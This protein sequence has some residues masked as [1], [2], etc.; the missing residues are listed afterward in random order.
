MQIKPAFDF[1]KETFSEWTDDEVPQHAAALAYYTI[2]S[3]APLLLV[4]IAI[5]GLV[6]GRDAVQGRLVGEIGGLV[7]PQ[8]GQAIQTMVANAGRH[9]SGVLA[10]IVG[11]VTILF[12]AMGVFTQL[13]SSLDHIWDVRPKPGR[14]I[15]GIVMSRAAAFGMLLGIGFLL[16]VSLVLS[17]ALTA[18]GAYLTGLLPAAKVLLQVVNEL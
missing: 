16:L 3:L 2:F 15:K 9:G 4:V 6:F 12:G 10:T 17:A 5:A 8:G 18:V 1:L 13:Q 11:V 7:G 14:G